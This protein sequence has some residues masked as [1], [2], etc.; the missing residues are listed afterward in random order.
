M[1]ISP[2]PG[3][4]VSFRNH[5]AAAACYGLPM[6]TSPNDLWSIYREGLAAFLAAV[7]RGL[8]DGH[9][10]DGQA[11]AALLALAFT[12]YGLTPA[13]LSRDEDVSKGAISRWVNGK[14]LPSTPTRKAV[15]LWV[16]RGLREEVDRTSA[17][18]RSAAGDAE[19]LP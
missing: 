5:V 2:P 15:A 13:A 16:L 11:F 3:N 18:I 1:R 17:V 7:E 8:A 6:R 9:S 10:F 4:P 12:R 14:A 19:R